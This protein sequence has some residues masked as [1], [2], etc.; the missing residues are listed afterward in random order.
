MSNWIPNQKVLIFTSVG[1][2][3]CILIYFGGLS[4]LLSEI[5]KIEQT[6]TEAALK[7]NQRERAQTLKLVAETYEEDLT[8]LRNF[9]LRKGDEVVFIEETE[10]L[11]RQSGL[12]FEIVSINPILTTEAEFKEDIELRVGIEG[13]WRQIMNFLEQ[14]EKASFGVSVE[15]VSIDATAPGEWSGFVEF[16]VFREK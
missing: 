14:L 6:Y 13:S 12:D 15:N 4:F 5:G 9:Y 7:I 16:I 11:A 2:L 8:T 1:A 3:F 10:S